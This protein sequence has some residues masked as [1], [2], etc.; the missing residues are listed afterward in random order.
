MPDRRLAQTIDVV[1]RRGAKPALH[2]H[3][4]AVTQSPVTRRAVDVEPFLAAIHHLRRER[5]RQR[6]HLRQIS[7]RRSR[8]AL[9]NVR[10]GP[11][12]KLSRRFPVAEETA[13]RQ[14][15]IFRLILLVLWA[16]GA[17]KRKDL[18]GAE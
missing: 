14:R 11:F 18:W 8:F 12:N 10:R 3:S 6:R 17:A 7:Y 13:R 4:V 1:R 16:G 9:G 15:L 5:E 2:D